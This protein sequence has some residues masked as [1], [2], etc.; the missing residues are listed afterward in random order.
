MSHFT[1]YVFQKDKDYNELLAP[2]DENLE[3]APYIKYTKTQAI[4]KVRKEIEDYKNGLYAEYLKDPETYKKNSNEKHINYIEN[5]FP[6]RLKWTD[7]ECYEDVRNW[8]DEDDVDAE[9]NIWSTYNP[10]SKWDWYEVGGRWSECL[11]TKEGNKTN[12]DLV[13]EIDFD[14]TPIPFAFIDPFGRWDERGEMGWWAIV[15][16]EKDKDDWENQYRN[17]VASLDKDIT[18]T[19]IDCHI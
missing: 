12:E 8:Y 15:S 6:K 16:N 1:V 9:G 18:V 13:S 14:K 10:N 2:Y 5:E 3:V 7:E 17:F 11:V 4:A 19:A